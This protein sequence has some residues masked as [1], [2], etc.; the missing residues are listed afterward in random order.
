M[1]C[2]SCRT[3]FERGYWSLNERR[4]HSSSRTKLVCK[5]CR[6]KGFHAHDIRTY[7]CQTCAGTFG[8]QKFKKTDLSNYKSRKVSRLVCLACKTKIRC[9][10]CW[11]QF[12]AGYWSAYERR[13]HCKSRLKVVCKACRA[14]GLHPR[15]TQTYT[16]QTCTGKFGSLKFDKTLLWNYK[17]NI[18]TTLRCLECISVDGVHVVS[19]DCRPSC[20]CDKQGVGEF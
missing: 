10:S 9:S 5:A 11:T 18:E 19:P 6:A 17:R 15:D 14:K 2:S 13:N 12:E 4:N 16:C 7:R 1:R 3:A 20:S 8:S